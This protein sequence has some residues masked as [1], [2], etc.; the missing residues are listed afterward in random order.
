MKILRIDCS[1]RAESQSRKLSAALVERLLAMD[2]D[3]HVTHR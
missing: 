1:P 3:A 2:P